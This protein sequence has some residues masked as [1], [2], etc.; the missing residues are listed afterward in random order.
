MEAMEKGFTFTLILNVLWVIASAAM[1]TVGLVLLTKLQKF[2]T[3][4][5]DKWAN[6]F[7]LTVFLWAVSGLLFAGSFVAELMVKNL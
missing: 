6:A 2:G 4:E 3:K 5:Y 7:Y 1:T